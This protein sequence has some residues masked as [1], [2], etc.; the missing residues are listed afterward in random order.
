MLL[1][2]AI[3]YFSRDRD[4]RRALVAFVVLLATLCVLSIFFFPAHEGPYAVTHGPV[5]ELRVL[6][7]SLSLALSLMLLAAGCLRI[8]PMFSLSSAQRLPVAVRQLAVPL[9]LH[10]VL[11][12]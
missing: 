5:T 9:S 1:I 8:A 11:R 7:S 2:V 3:S 10:Q 6:L 4:G 12:C